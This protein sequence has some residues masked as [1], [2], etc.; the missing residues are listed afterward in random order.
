MWLGGEKQQHVKET[1]RINDQMKFYRPLDIQI[2]YL[3]LKYL[4][5]LRQEVA[6]VLM[7]N[8]KSGQGGN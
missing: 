6:K 1:F 7:D 2:S 5:P 4:N 8:I 3:D